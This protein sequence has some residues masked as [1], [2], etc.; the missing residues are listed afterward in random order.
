M[1]LKNNENTPLTYAAVA[2]KNATPTMEFSYPPATPP[3]RLVKFIPPP[4]QR[5]WDLYPRGETCNWAGLVEGMARRRAKVV[6]QVGKEF[7]PI[8]VMKLRRER[9]NRRL[10]RRPKEV[11]SFGFNY[12]VVAPSE[13][14]CLKEAPQAP[15]GPI[16]V[17]PMPASRVFR[18]KRFYDRSNLI[19]DAQRLLRGPILE[20]VR[21]NGMLRLLDFHRR[22]E[23]PNLRTLIVVL[24]YNRLNQMALPVN[25]IENQ[26]LFSIFETK[27]KIDVATENVS[28]A[29]ANITKLTEKLN[30]FIAPVTEKCTR[31]KEDA[32]VS[33]GN[34]IL[35]K[36]MDTE[37]KSSG[38]YN[39][40]S[41]VL[42]AIIGKSKYIVCFAVFNMYKQIFGVNFKCV[43]KLQEKISNCWERLASLTK[44][45]LKIQPQ[46]GFQ[47]L[48][49]TEKSIHEVGGALFSAV[50]L[51]C[52]I[53]AVPPTSYGNVSKL[54]NN[55]GTIPRGQAFACQFFVTMFKVLKK[56]TSRIA[57]FFS[58]TH[59]DVALIAGMED[60]RLK[61]W[62]ME[63][64]AMTDQSIHDQVLANPQ[65]ANKIFELSIV[66][67]GIM[68]AFISDPSKMPKAFTLV[69]DV[70]SKLV[71]LENKLIK[72]KVFSGARYEPY[73]LWV[74]GVAGTM[75]TTFM[76]LF[77]ENIA[78]SVGYS[79]AQAYYPVT[80]GQ[81]FFDGYSNQPCV[82]FDDFLALSPSHD[83]ET[84]VQFLQMK[85]SSQF[86]PP[87]SAVGDK[88][89]FLNFP[90]LGITSNFTS[91]SAAPGIHDEQAY[92]RR[93][94]LV[95]KFQFMDPTVNVT[96]MHSKYSKEQIANFE[97]ITPYI[98]DSPL[99]CGTWIPLPIISGKTVLDSI[100]TY[101]MKHHQTYNE[102]QTDLYLRRSQAFRERLE[103][104]SSKNS[105]TG[106]L[107][108]VISVLDPSKSDEASL[109]D[110]ISVWLKRK[111]DSASFPEMQDE[112]DE[113]ILP[114]KN[115]MEGSLYEPIQRDEGEYFHN[116]SDSKCLHD[117]FD[118]GNIYYESGFDAW[119]SLDCVKGKPQSVS[120]GPCKVVVKR[121]SP[122]GSHD[123]EYTLKS[124]PKCS[125][126]NKENGKEEFYK[127]LV[128][129]ICSHSPQSN[130]AF[131]R[132]INTPEA[133][134]D[135]YPPDFYVA[136]PKLIN[137]IDYKQRK[138]DKDV[139]KHKKVFRLINKEQDSLKTGFDMIGR[140]VVSKDVSLWQSICEYTKWVTISTISAICYILKAIRWIAATILSVVF[141]I[142]MAKHMIYGMDV[143]EDPVESQL[144]PSGDYKTLKSTKQV[145]NRALRLVKSEVSPQNNVLHQFN[146]TSSNGLKMKV[147]H[148]MFYLV[149]VA[150]QE[151]GDI[152]YPSICLGLFNKK[153]IV[154]KHYIEHFKATGCEEVAVL[155]NNFNGYK[156]YK[157]A[158][159]DF[160]WVE[161]SGYGVVTFPAS[162]PYM[163]R[164]IRKN[165]VS[166]TFDGGY[167]SDATI[168]ELSADG[169]AE[170]SVRIKTL[171][172]PKIVPG[173]LTQSSWVISQG[174]EYDWGGKG[175]CGSILFC[176]TM[177]SPI[178]GIHTAGL[179]IKK[180]FSEML[181]RETFEE[182]ED[183]P[184]EY[185]EPQIDGSPV[186]SVEGE[187]EVVGKLESHCVVNQPTET[188][189]L[190]SI[191]HGVFP[192]TTEPA[193]L[194]S[195]DSRLP[196]GEFC[197]P[198]V[199]G[200]NKRCE[201]TR[202]FSPSDLGLAVENLT[203]KLI[204]KC[205]PV[206]SEVSVLS[207]RESVEGFRN[208][209]GYDSMEMKTSEGYPWRLFRPSAA[210]DK[211]W[212]FDL[213]YDSQGLV[214]K[215]INGDLKDTLKEKDVLR[216][217]GIVPNTYFTACLKDARILKEKVSQPGK[218]RIF[219]ISPVELTIAQRQYFLDFYVA[220]QTSRF[221]VEN[222]VGINPDGE[223]W[224]TLALHLEEFSPHV[225]TADYSGYG[226][227][228][229]SSVLFGVFEVIIKWYEHHGATEKESL[230][231]RVMAHEITHGLHVA[232]DCVFRPSAGMPSGNPGTVIKNSVA[233]SLYIRLAFLGLARKYETSK[234]DLFF[235]EKFVKLFHNGDDLIISVKS[236]ILPWFN[237]STLIEF[238]AEYGLKMTD[239]LKQGVVRDSCA[240][241]DATYLKRGF[242]P[243]PKRDH[244]YLAPLE[245]ASIT[246][247]ANWIW[248]CVNPELASLVNSEMSLRLAY[249]QGPKYYA[250]IY[251]TLKRKWRQHGHRFEAPGW[252]IIDENVWDKKCNTA[253]KYSEIEPQMETEGSASS[254]QPTIHQKSNVIIQDLNP[255]EIGKVLPIRKGFEKMAISSE[256]QRYETMV[257]RW[258][259]A[260]VITWKTTHSLDE[261]I[262]SI[263]LPGDVIKRNQNSANAQLFLT[264]R[265]FRFDNMEIKVCLNTNPFQVG[266]LV[267]SW[268]YGYQTNF[269]QYQSVYS[270]VQRNHVLLTAGNSNSVVLK[271]PYYNIDSVTT[272]GKEDGVIGNLEIYVLNPLIVS[273]NVSSSATF[274]VYVT[275]ENP[276][277]YGLISRGIMTKGLQE[278]E[279]QM[280]T[281]GH[282]INAAPE[283]LSVIGKEFN[284]DNPPVP[285]QPISLV[286]QA[287]PSFCYTDQVGE[288]LNVLRAGST[289]Q[290]PTSVLT[291]EMDPLVIAQKWGLLTTV[292]WSASQPSNSLLFT[293]SNVPLLPQEKYPGLANSV[294]KSLQFV[295]TPLAGI[296]SFYGL[297]RGD[298]EYRLDIVASHFHRG[299]L[300]IGSVPLY[301]VSDI[302]MND[303][304]LSAHMVA[305][306]ND[307]VS[308]SFLAPW[309]WYN[310][311]VNNRVH[312]STFSSP[313]NLFIKVVNPLIAI[314][315]VPPKVYI[316][317]YVRAGN[318]FE[319]AV[320]RHPIIQPA[321]GSNVVPPP[322][323]VLIPYNKEI[324]VYTSWERNLVRPLANT[325][326]PTL[327]IQNITDGWVGFTNAKLGK[328]YEL[329][330]TTKDGNKFRVF[331]NHRTTSNTKYTEEVRYG[332]Y[333]PALSTANAHGLVVFPGTDRWKPYW[334][335]YAQDLL[336]AG[337]DVNKQKE[338]R[339]STPIWD[340]DGPYS[341]ISK[342]GGKTWVP[343]VNSSDELVWNQIWPETFDLL[344][345]ALEEGVSPQMNTDPIITLNEPTASTREGRLTFGENT[346][347]LKSLCRRWNYLSAFQ[348]VP[349][350]AAHVRECPVSFKINVH[351]RILFDK[352]KSSKAFE[353]RAREGALTAVS[354]M[355]AFWRGGLRY[356]FVFS[357][358]KATYYIQ[359]RFDEYFGNTGPTVEIPK[360]G[361]ST[362]RDLMLPQ[363][364]TFVQSGTVN[365][366][367]TVEVPY[368]QPQELLRCQT[369]TSEATNGKLYCWVHSPDRQPVTVSV[370]M[371]FADDTRCSVFQ[372]FPRS[373]D[374]TTISPEVENQK[375]RP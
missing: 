96:N 256:D 48:D 97:H 71:E 145:K 37:Q 267:V 65:F 163:F 190:P 207:V 319:F 260:D 324:K 370:Y 81:K 360:P 183:I 44:R 117:V 310:A 332:V 312:E 10:N 187:A 188:K 368:Y 202:E 140:V 20:P 247:T 27:K 77:A 35:Q 162:L 359:H 257:D 248:R 101:V 15:E 311:W 185:A 327:Y 214:L 169:I 356:R 6:R 69:K 172:S 176:P 88:D 344:T 168:I 366:T 1:A 243:H 170:Y 303:L 279:P 277:F 220:Y 357:V 181:F 127:K 24:N 43:L 91:F 328:V 54:V 264:H 135:Q 336:E 306:I 224:T 84:Y 31:V 58:P 137:R 235:F 105:L 3:T 174:F 79:G 116:S 234:C 339:K 348:I 212:L 156:T 26:G 269:S 281:I 314:D 375:K 151:D 255:V 208:V 240:L 171:E 288:P 52:N 173:T 133:Q 67:K 198:F 199:L 165:I 216:R 284:R 320:L 263:S 242:L 2:A 254:K 95:L 246:D 57:D 338:A 40:F 158:E 355:F 321:I 274:S 305:D 17:G 51:A 34:W 102:K 272:L 251:Q 361:V 296:A 75:K 265:W 78:S 309:F 290:T 325:Y 59:S 23:N 262:Y 286:P 19:S 64:L 143:E 49:D 280:D 342:D 291:N 164:D 152:S 66:G 252:D 298:L 323:E 289:G 350:E 287:M 343:A 60:N 259:L 244:Q 157:L 47:D 7:Y 72:R 99:E 334:K 222:T 22:T 292:S 219:E 236:E 283:V 89:T 364:A 308:I 14:P 178:V 11:E 33:I 229:N 68:Q 231:R 119:L 333:D 21:K 295:P 347:D 115:F 62:L 124:H 200:V 46:D 160:E 5:T 153:A 13:Q 210:K 63:A 196:E 351:P 206:R 106:Y 238:F 90:V 94:D 134:T 374:I 304:K 32:M 50:A 349:C 8:G 326:A 239:A 128:D 25:E 317:L 73:C 273:G 318:N 146:I 12:V 16:D 111:V 268:I 275:F 372:G 297:W 237:N 195:K 228:M 282:L 299:K 233:N 285:L 136:L 149:G 353:N 92:N 98:A 191:I 315:N 241:L 204:D 369:T 197:D 123:I 293:T 29:A 192:V 213:E 276:R 316:N 225:L 331:L 186:F 177:A 36:I 261:K 161:G 141:V 371:S 103:T 258:I 166:E 121:E 120:D 330:S 38:I 232:R 159:L 329:S 55:I 93:R 362:Y 138:L 184:I 114:N 155:K 218:T 108:E 109:K 86:N 45:P 130:L 313:T 175:R 148:N 41:H 142:G 61:V 118:S 147:I 278:I 74:S 294:E 83:P 194:S 340:M 249:T 100:M 337:D 266:Q 209:V 179:G 300:M 139:I 167:P 104:C 245:K 352:V 335:L 18:K 223:E 70:Y 230:V 85:S 193:P 42:Y 113:I 189:I 363:Y 56:V 182:F 345:S 132:L 226:P 4:P 9:R 30:S 346:P 302:D 154:L 227:R 358:S 215:G 180:G 354:S 253:F 217:Q 271:V 129:N 341:E 150:H 76:Q 125:L 367:L 211:S 80:P 39:F 112:S 107:S 144:H 301:D 122:S 87:F 82:Y 110:R 270:A 221:D 322:D 203:E 373:I 131:V 201:P 126:V 28:E 365:R 307:S 205:I 53:K 250:S